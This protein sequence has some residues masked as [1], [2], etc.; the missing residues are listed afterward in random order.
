MRRIEPRI[1]S[2]VRDKAVRGCGRVSAG[3]QGHVALQQMLTLDAVVEQGGIQAGAKYLHR[4][5]P[6]VVTALKNLEQELGFALFDRSG[7]RLSLTTE[8]KPFHRA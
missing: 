5:H 4:T 8:G 7:Y 3:K 2:I 1:W 6:S